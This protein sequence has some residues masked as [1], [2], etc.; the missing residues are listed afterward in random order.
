M[1][2]WKTIVYDE[3]T[4]CGIHLKI[5]FMICITSLYVVFGHPMKNVW[6]NALTK[7][8]RSLIYIQERRSNVLSMKQDYNRN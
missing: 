7:G 4:I 2:Q 1:V 5:K 6:C 8:Y 3:K